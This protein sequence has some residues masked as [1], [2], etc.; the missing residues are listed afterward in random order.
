MLRAMC[1]VQLKHRK[2]VNYL[3]TM[4]GLNNLAIVC[5]GVGWCVRMWSF[6]KIGILV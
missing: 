5:P 1:G 2:R 6:V 3:M 4:V